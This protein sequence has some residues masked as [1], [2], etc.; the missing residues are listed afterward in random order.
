MVERKT[1]QPYLFAVL[2]ILLASVV[3]AAPAPPVFAFASA[4]STQP[5]YI[6]GWNP[7][8]TQSSIKSIKD[9]L[10]S[11]QFSIKAS[12]NGA[13]DT[14]DLNLGACN[15]SAMYLTA[16]MAKQLEGDKSVMWIEKEVEMKTFADVEV[17]GRILY[18]LDLLDGQL[19]NRF[20]IPDQAGLGVDIYVLDTGIFAG[21]SEFQGRGQL[22]ADFAGGNIGNG[23][24]NIHGT[25]VSGTAAGTRA[26]VAKNADIF[27]VRVLGENGGGS[28]LTVAQ[29][30]E[31]VVNTVQRTGRPSVINMS[32]GGAASTAVDA[33]VRR[34]VNAGIPVVV[35]AGNE[36]QNAC[37]GSPSREPLAITVG[38]SDVDNKFASFSN[39]GECVDII[40][41][42]VQIASAANTEAD[43]FTRLSGTSMASPLVAGVVATLLSTGV[44]AEQVRDKLVQSARPGAIQGDLRGTPNLLVSL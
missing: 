23:D 31:F 33:A 30:I 29:G 13:G 9:D 1:M 7:N 19:N 34:A 39:F 26:G 38:A 32:L 8:A 4:P 18:N 28:S 25:H 14:I 6:I 15:A 2:A 36:N 21:H 22:L 44:P 12:A 27:G 43:Q 20:T 17:N 11:Q 35:A 41:P 37:G 24:L 5:R 3:N 10:S 16:A 40:A 42:G